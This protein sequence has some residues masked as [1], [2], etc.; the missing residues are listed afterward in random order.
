[1]EALYPKSEIVGAIYTEDGFEY[2]YSSF[3]E[4]LNS[5]VGRE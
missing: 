5:A 3:G 1:M 2:V 4:I